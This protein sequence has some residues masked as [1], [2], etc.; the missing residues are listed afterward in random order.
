MATYQERVSYS[1]SSSTSTLGGQIRLNDGDGTLTVRDS[2]TNQVVT[3]VDRNGVKLFDI[4]GREMTRLD[5]LGLTTI[6]AAT[7]QFKNRV[8]ITSDNGRTIIATA[9]P[10]IDLRSKGI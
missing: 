7:G 2:R 3:L 9:K 10:G 6:E 5:T 8:G 4:L 1:G